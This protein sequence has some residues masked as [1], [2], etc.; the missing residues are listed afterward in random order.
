MQAL[1]S[2]FVD[3]FARM[4]LQ[5]NAAKTEV[6]VSSPVVKEIRVQ[7]RSMVRHIRNQH[8]GEQSPRLELEDIVSPL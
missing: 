2:Q 3:L 6:M 8:S 1:L 5:M 7:K 4:G